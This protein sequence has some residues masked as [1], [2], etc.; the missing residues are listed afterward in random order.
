[1]SKGIKRRIKRV[2]K[3]VNQEIADS[4][5]DSLYSRGL[6]REGYMGG[7]AEALN[8]VMLALNGVKP[9]RRDWWTKEKFKGYEE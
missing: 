6:S 9:V 7:Y 1:M 5:H 2:L 8:D 4:T 3:K